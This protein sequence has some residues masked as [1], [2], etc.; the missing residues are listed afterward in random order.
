MTTPAL[1]PFAGRGF[2]VA[3]PGLT[4]HNIYADDGRS[5]RYF[6]TEGA[7][8]GAQGVSPFEWREVAPGVFSISW[9]EAS[10]A[11][12]VHVDDFVRGLS[13]TFFTTP[14]LQFFVMQG[15]LTPLAPSAAA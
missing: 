11:T 14:D 12:V 4:A 7:H 3:Y 5:V 15:T 8:A 9:Q 6:I 2:V 1:P 13:Q 10:G